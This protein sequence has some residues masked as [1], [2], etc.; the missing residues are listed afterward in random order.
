MYMI[1]RWASA[2]VAAIAAMTQVLVAKNTASNRIKSACGQDAFPST[3]I[4]PWSVDY[5]QLTYMLATGQHTASNHWDCRI[6]DVE[7]LPAT[8]APW[9]TPERWEAL[10]AEQ[11]ATQA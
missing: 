7:A 2:K 8:L 1:E 9:T 11:Q 3:Y 5:D 10:W 6:K 4:H